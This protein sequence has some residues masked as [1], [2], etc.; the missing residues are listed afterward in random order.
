M[1]NRSLP[2]AVAMFLLVG[3]GSVQKPSATF[4]SADVGSATSKGVQLSFGIDV[5]NPNSFEL[6]ISGASYKLGLGDVP[7]LDDT[8]KPSASIPA[9]GSLPV[10][11]PVSL[12]FEK[13]LSAE[14]SLANSGGKVPYDFSGELQFSAGPLKAIGQSIKVPVK[15]SGT[16]DF[17]KMLSDPVALMQS[18][19]GKRVL[20]MMLGKGKL[21]D[22]LEKIK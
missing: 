15:A 19:A 5:S 9:K 13:L 20:E 12:T 6:P 16:L 22:L 7:V 10:T 3:C 21:S 4:R 18:P 11:I 14:K 8:A 2:F 1:V 17:R